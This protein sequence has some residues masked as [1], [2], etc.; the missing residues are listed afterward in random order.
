MKYIKSN[1]LVGNEAI[2]VDVDE[3]VLET[4]I[5]QVKMIL[6]NL[7]FSKG[8]EDFINSAG[9]KPI[10]GALDF[11][12]YIDSLG[13]TIFYVSNRNYKQIDALTKN[14]NNYNFPQVN[15]NNI[16]LKKNS[17]NKELRRK[18]ISSKHNILLLIGDSLEDFSDI[19]EANNNEDRIKNVQE[20]YN[21]FGRKF[22][23][24]PNSS[25]GTWESLI[26]NNDWNLSFETRDS[27]RKFTLKKILE[28][29]E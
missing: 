10:S 16:Y 17:S 27:L 21:L 19:F 23:V 1:G 5:F 12:N 11:L 3:T 14:L 15:D 4:S 2:V 26:Y 28:Q 18:D 20:N 6:E 7:E 9:C 29:Y 13:I 8:W 25:Y 22:I 24:I